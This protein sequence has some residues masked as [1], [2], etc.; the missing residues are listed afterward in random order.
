MIHSNR[1]RVS[2]YE[3][4]GAN[5]DIRLFDILRSYIKEHIVHTAASMLTPVYNDMSRLNN[6]LCNFEADFQYQC[7][8]FGIDRTETRWIDPSFTNSLYIFSP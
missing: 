8:R 3:K 1:H 5:N 6:L 4:Y 7:I 2:L